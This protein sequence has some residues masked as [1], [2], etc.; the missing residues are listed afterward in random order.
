ME[1]TEEHFT[2][3]GIQSW[4]PSTIFTEFP[5]CARDTEMNKTSKYSALIEFRFWWEDGK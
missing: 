2:L 3:S 1:D 5:L 4:F